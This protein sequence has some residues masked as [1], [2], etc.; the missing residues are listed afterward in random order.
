MIEN[1]L[2]KF[3]YDM[4]VALAILA[5]LLAW[6]FAKGRKDPRSKKAPTSREQRET[7]QRPSGESPHEETDSSPKKKPRA[8]QEGSADEFT[9]AKQDIVASREPSDPFRPRIKGPHSDLSS[10]VEAQ[11]LAPGMVYALAYGDYLNSFGLSDS[12]GITK[13]LKRDWDITDRSTLLRQ[14]YSMLRDGHRS[15]YNDLRKKA[16]DLAASQT[17]V[18]P[19]F[20][21][22]RWRELSRFINDE[23]GLQT[24]NFTA[25]DLM[26]AANLTRAGEGLGWMT[27]DE[28][29][30]TLALINHGLRT[31]YSSW[32][33][34]C[35]AFIVTRWLWLNEE[36]EAMEAS[37]L[38]DQRR[39]EALVGPNGVWNKIPWDGTYPSP[40]YLLLDASDE[41]FQLNPMSRFEWEDAPRW[42]RELDD[43]SHKRIQERKER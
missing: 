8:I 22:S 1:L 24:T 10:S 36:G 32:E 41:N 34:A 27:R 7:T 35:D 9:S 17:R 4:W 31:T 25:W 5:G 18:N 20:P 33:E 19:G 13:M 21:K 3:S 30:D 42:E 23:R 6:A 16:L 43:E 40:R 29:E 37:D 2:S 26:R 39:R 15:Y 12:R 14:I 38:H 28:A 11:L